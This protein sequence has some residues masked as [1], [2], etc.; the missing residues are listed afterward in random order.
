[1]NDCELE[2][3]TPKGIVLWIVIASATMPNHQRLWVHLT[4]PRTTQINRDG[5]GVSASAK[6]RTYDDDSVQ[7]HRSHLKKPAISLNMWQFLFFAAFA[8][9]DEETNTTKTPEPTQLPT[10]LYWGLVFGCTAGGAVIMGILGA[11]AVVI[12][13]RERNKDYEPVMS[14]MEH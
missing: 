4:N 2:I 13:N 6:H 14:T 9:L 7:L 10:G 8:L 3:E 11:I 12:M 1:M 5:P